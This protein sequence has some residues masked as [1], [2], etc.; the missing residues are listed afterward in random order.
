MAPPA[1]RR[2]PL[3]AGVA[4]PAHARL[5]PAGRRSNPPEQACTGTRR[6][7]KVDQPR[8]AGAAQPQPGQ[9]PTAAGPGPRTAAGRWAW[10]LLLLVEGLTSLIQ[11]PSPARR[12]RG[13]RRADRRGRGA[14]RRALAAARRAPRHPRQQPAA[15]AGGSAARLS[16]G[17]A[18]RRRRKSRAPQGQARGRPKA[19]PRP[20]AEPAATAESRRPAADHRATPPDRPEPAAERWPYRLTRWRAVSAGVRR[21]WV[22]ASAVSSSARGVAPQRGGRVAAR[23]PRHQ[24]IGEAVADH[25]SAAGVAGEPLEQGPR[26]GR[27]R[28]AGIPVAVADRGVKELVDA[29]RRQQRSGDLAR[30][31]GEH[32][33]PPRRLGTQALQ[34][35]RRSRGTAG[36]ARRAGRGR[37]SRTLSASA[38][39]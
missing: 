37:S 23:R 11:R 17:P 13:R 33:Q 8:A 25:E 22:G 30:L 35:I 39:G 2:A 1:R 34:Q 36:T 9:E 3:R 5:V 6:P 7:R 24:Q 28:L 18:A 14:G 12:P 10:R 27:V 38:C 4:R 31:V 29:E 32:R 15:P 21:S 16:R 19:G 26:G 20:Q